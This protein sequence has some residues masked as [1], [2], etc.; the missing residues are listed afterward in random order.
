MKLSLVF[1]ITISLEMPVPSQG[2]YV[3]TV[4]LLLILSV[5]IFME[6]GP[7]STLIILTPLHTF[8]SEN[9]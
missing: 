9:D 1:N 7:K 4:F 6:I 3:F 2:H 5:Y 8:H